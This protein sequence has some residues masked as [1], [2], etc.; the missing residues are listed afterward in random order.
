M[1]L[2][3]FCSFPIILSYLP[4]ICAFDWTWLT[5]AHG[6]T[7]TSQLIVHYGSTKTTQACTMSAI[8]A[9]KTSLPHG[10]SFSTTCKAPSM[11]IVSPATSTS[12]PCRTSSPITIT[13]T[14][15]ARRVIRS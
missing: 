8:R 15:T 5:T 3:Q 11:T 4:H 14:G 10:V 1:D 12:V 13:L 2:A 9:I 6:A 7:A